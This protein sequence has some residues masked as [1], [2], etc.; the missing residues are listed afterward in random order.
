MEF[1]ELSVTCFISSSVGL[2][3]KYGIAIGVDCDGYTLLCDIDGG[4]C[5]L[6]LVLRRADIL[7]VFTDMG[8]DCAGDCFGIELVLVLV[9]VIC[10]A[11]ILGVFTD[12]GRDCAGDCFG[13]ELILV[14]RARFDSVVAR[15]EGGLFRS[16]S[17]SLSI[18]GRSC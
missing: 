18:A 16:I 1:L 8:R 17:G 14:I 4:F 13:I 2:T 10:R 3:V 15:L 7:G 6:D 9:L 5:F 12:M 11:D